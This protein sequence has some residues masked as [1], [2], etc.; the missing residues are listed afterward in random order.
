MGSSL[1]GR[2]QDGVVKVKECSEVEP[3][4]DRPLVRL[5]SSAECHLV[6]VGKG[7]EWES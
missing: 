4:G 3:S 1:Y 7:D 6:R 2:S 5:E